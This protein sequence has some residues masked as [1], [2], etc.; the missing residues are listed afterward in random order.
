MEMGGIFLKWMEWEIPKSVWDFDD[1]VVFFLIFFKKLLNLIENCRMRKIVDSVTLFVDSV[2]IDRFWHTDLYSLYS[3]VKYINGNGTFV[4]WM[5]N[6]FEM[7]GIF[8]KWEIFHSH[9]MESFGKMEME[10]KPF[11]LNGGSLVYI[12]VFVN[13][14][15]K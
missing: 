4:K 7:S 3:A 6:E 2:Q 12:D 5:G 13:R 11:F 15:V 9:F 10:W 1:F 8:V 14:F